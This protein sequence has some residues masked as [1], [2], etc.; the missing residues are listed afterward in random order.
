MNALDLFILGRKNLS[1]KRTYFGFFFQTLSILFLNETISHSNHPQ[2]L[3]VESHPVNAKFKLTSPGV[4]AR[5]G[6]QL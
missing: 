2:R 4:I 5:N 3:R 1:K 6:S